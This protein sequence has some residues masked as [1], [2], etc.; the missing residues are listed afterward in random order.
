M[1]ALFFLKSAEQTVRQKRKQIL[2]IAAK[3]G[4]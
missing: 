4:A 2:E 3:Y 1:D